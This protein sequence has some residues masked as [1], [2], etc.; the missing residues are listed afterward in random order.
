MVKLQN[1][2]SRVKIFKTCRGIYSQNREK[3]GERP[4]AGGER[5]VAGHEQECGFEKGTSR[6]LDGLGLGAETARRTHSTLAS[7]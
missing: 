7:H 6:R 4:A 3:L 1:T 5:S 2:K